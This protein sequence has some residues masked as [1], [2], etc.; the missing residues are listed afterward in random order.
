MEKL[1]D[2]ARELASDQF[3]QDRAKHEAD[4]HAAKMRVDEAEK[5]I[6]AIRFELSRAQGQIEEDA[7]TQ[8]MLQGVIE[9]TQD[10]LGRAQAEAAAVTESL[11]R[12]QNRHEAE[13][14]TW[15]IEVDRGRQDLIASKKVAASLES[16]SNKLR[17][18][19]DNL[20]LS[21]DALKKLDQQKDRALFEQNIKLEEQTKALIEAQNKAQES[22]LN[23]TRKLKPCQNKIPRTASNR[24]R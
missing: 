20:T 4:A 3:A 12:M 11:K 7:K 21:L 5:A 15:L 18:M 13:R 1:W 8:A 2:E 16:Q 10:A 9:S 17:D 23:R 19:V 24:L 6:D 14:K 22:K